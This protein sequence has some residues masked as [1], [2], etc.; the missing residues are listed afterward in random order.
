M[1][2]PP[3]VAAVEESPSGRYTVLVADPPL[4]AYQ[5]GIGGLAP[6]DPTVTGAT[7]LDADSAASRAYLAY[8]AGRHSAL[9]SAIEA[10]LGRAV[11]PMFTY[12]TVL[13]GIVVE[14]SAAEAGQVAGLPGVTAVV[15]DV[16]LQLLTDNGPA[17]IGAPSI[18]S[19]EAGGVGTRGEGIVVGIIDTGINTDHPSFADVGGD[20]YNHT[21]PARHVPWAVRSTDRRALL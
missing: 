2:A 16:E 21:E 6:T 10:A 18:W 4:A 17:W 3:L 15:P 7:R 19:G 5:G 1:A 9:E 8:L 12:E 14:M 11:S 20:G 13:N